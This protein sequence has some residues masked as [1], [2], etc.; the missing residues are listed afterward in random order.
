MI[1]HIC[2]W[3]FELEYKNY[4]VDLNSIEHCYEQKYG[5]LFT[6]DRNVEFILRILHF[7]H[8]ALNN[9]YDKNLTSQQTMSNNLSVR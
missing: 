2:H 9:K 1:W 3:E 4:Y 7:P 8:S 6:I 5:Y